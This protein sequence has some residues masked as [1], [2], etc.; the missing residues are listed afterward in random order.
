MDPITNYVCLWF[1]LCTK[2]KFPVSFQLALCQQEIHRYSIANKYNFAD[3][4]QLI[5]VLNASLEY[6]KKN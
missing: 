6:S 4:K 5:C 1:C 2:F 3:R